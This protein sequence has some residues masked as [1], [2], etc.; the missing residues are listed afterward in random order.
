MIINSNKTIFS[1]SLL[2]IF[3]DLSIFRVS[4]LIM[5]RA[6]LNVLPAWWQKGWLGWEQISSWAN[7]SNLGTDIMPLSS[8]AERTAQ[9][10]SFQSTS[11]ASE[12]CHGNRRTHPSL[13]K[14]VAGREERTAPKTWTQRLGGSEEEGEREGDVDASLNLCVCFSLCDGMMKPWRKQCRVPG[15][16]LSLTLSDLSFNPFSSAPPCHILLSFTNTAI[17]H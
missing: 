11:C 5:Q 12:R 16:H 17:S 15:N 10:R 14:S 2:R 8:T 13:R 4:Y 1:C 6:N 9:R 7:I 3:I